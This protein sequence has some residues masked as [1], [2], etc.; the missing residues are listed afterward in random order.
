[1]CGRLRNLTTLKL[2]LREWKCGSDRAFKSMDKSI[3]QLTLLTDLDLSLYRVGYYSE[4]I[5]E[6]SLVSVAKMCGSLRSLTILKLYLE[7]W[8]CGSD[9]AFEEM[10]KS[11]SQLT[12]LT[13]LDLKL[14]RVGYYSETISDR[15]LVSIVQ[16]CGS[17]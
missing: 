15:S 2:N 7:E 17:L 4:T 6:S 16:M 11:I 13:H 3:S 5:S 12:L 9:R 14:D 1:M 8:S 10:N